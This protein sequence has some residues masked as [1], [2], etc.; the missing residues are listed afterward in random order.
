MSAG[1]RKYDPVTGGWTTTSNINIGHILF[2]NF[3]VTYLEYY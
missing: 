3:G 2:D 1:I